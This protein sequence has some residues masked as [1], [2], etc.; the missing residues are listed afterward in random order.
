MVE[1][2]KSKNTKT[3]GDLAKETQEVLDDKKSSGNKI[4]VGMKIAIGVLAIIILGL[5]GY[6]MYQV[7]KDSTMIDSEKDL[8]VEGGLAGNGEG[9]ESAEVNLNN[10]ST[11][12]VANATSDNE[13]NNIV[14]NSDVTLSKEDMDKLS[15]EIDKLSAEDDEFKE[16]QNTF[17]EGL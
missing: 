9:N 16:V 14:D 5:L 6:I 3:A 1:K 2:N 10:D 12:D 15:S 13:A 4:P 17:D 7:G 11:S 8:I